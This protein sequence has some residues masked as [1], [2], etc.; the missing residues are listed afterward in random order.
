M[1]L[2]HSWACNPG[3]GGGG[4][5]DF[6]QTYASGGRM[7]GKSIGV[8]VSH[9]PGGIIRRTPSYVWTLARAPLPP[10]DAPLL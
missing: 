4:H 10:A 7:T 3:I 5:G 1:I 8:S 6:R 9:E 2:P